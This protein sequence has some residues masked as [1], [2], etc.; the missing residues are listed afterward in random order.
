MGDEGPGT[1]VAGRG[2]LSSGGVFPATRLHDVKAYGTHDMPIWER[3][4][5]S[6]PAPMYD[7]CAPNAEAGHAHESRP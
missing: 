3:H 5:A 4:F 1:V 6:R 7:D 2:A